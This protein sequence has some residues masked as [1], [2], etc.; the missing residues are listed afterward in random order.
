MRYRNRIV[1]WIPS[2]LTYEAGA[3]HAQVV[4]KETGDG[5]DIDVSDEYGGS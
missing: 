3:T 2:G 1:S 4:V 5:D